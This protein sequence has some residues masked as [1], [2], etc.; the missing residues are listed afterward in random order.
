MLVV[1]LIYMKIFALGK[2]GF[3]SGGSR[4]HRA[5]IPHLKRISPD[6][7]VI[8]Y[9]TPGIPSAEDKTQNIMSRTTH[10]DL[11]AILYF[12]GFWGFLAFIL[13]IIRYFSVVNKIPD[14]EIRQLLIFA[15]LSY[16]MFGISAES[17]V[18]KGQPFIFWPLIAIIAKRKILFFSNQFKNPPVA[19]TN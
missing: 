14:I 11:L 13:I 4:L 15:M 16:L 10:N 18:H 2:D 3:F 7:F 9:G 12:T 8:G 19:I 1:M 17:F 5:W 6:R